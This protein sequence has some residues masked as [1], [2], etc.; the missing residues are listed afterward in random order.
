MTEQPVRMHDDEIEI[1]DEIASELIRS[2]FSEW[3]ERPIQ[4]IQSGGTVNAI[5][6]I[7][8]DLAAR[9]PLRP[10]DPAEARKLLVDEARASEAF[11]RHC[12]VSSPIPVG[13]GDPGAR[14]PLPWSVQT[15]LSG[16][17]ASEAHVSQSVPLA[18]DLAR[19]IA[20]LRKV[21]TGG[22][23]FERGWRGGDL[24]DHDHWVQVCFEK[25]AHL[26]DVKRLRAMWDY[27][28][29]LPRTSADV[30]SHGDLTPL[31]VLV[32]GGRLVGVLDCGGFGPADPS[33]DVIAGW[34]LLDDAP[35]AIFRAEL[36]CDEL[37]W[38]RSKAWA[39]EQSL[40]AVWYYE[41]SNPAMSGMGRRTVERIIAHSS[42]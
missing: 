11:A 29:D 21:D 20:G 38:E 16:T 5:F 32:D 22:R 19:L 3:G 33:L 8:V 31:N 39:L 12:T 18:R 6:R 34:H 35:R 30:M 24:H 23:T 1:T 40:G 28:H 41:K 15:W 26:L 42:G 13:L 4:R 37:E 10:A 25:S 17:V 14:Y 9:F 27:Y 7:G 2:Q 36:K